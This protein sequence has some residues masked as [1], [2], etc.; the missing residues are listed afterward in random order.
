MLRKYASRVLVLA[1]FLLLPLVA[2][3]SPVTFSGFVGGTVSNSAL[4][5]FVTL[6]F[7]VNSD[8]TTI[9]T[10]TLA[11]IGLPNGTFTENGSFEFGL[12]F[13]QPSLLD[14]GSNPFHFTSSGNQA[15]VTFTVTQTGAQDV[16]LGGVNYHLTFALSQLSLSPGQ[17]A[18]VTATLTPSSAVPEP[19]TML[20]LGTGLAGI[21][22]KVRKRRKGV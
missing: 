16:T 9:T 4:N 1:A 20:L 19:T 6:P 10:I 18:D 2:Q 12:S 5:V 17:T 15:G 13:T 14:L 21:A 3:A 22:V 7:N 11:T 8:T